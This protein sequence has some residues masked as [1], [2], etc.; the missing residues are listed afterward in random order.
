MKGFSN[1]QISE[2]F[3]LAAGTVKVHVAAVYQVLR[4]KS[5][6]EAVEVARR[7]GFSVKNHVEHS[8][9]IDKSTSAGSLAFKAGH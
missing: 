7:I 3:N 4:V 6:V 2:K 9:H 1:K 5:R 8:N